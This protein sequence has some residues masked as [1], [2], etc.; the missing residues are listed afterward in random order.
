MTVQ[1]APN[2]AGSFHNVSHSGP[3]EHLQTVPLILYGPSIESNGRVGRPAGVV[4]IF[5]TM[6]RLAGVE[7]PGRAGRVL[8]EAVVDAA[9]P[10]KLILTVVWD[11]AGR[12][13]LEEWRG[14]WRTLAR[15]EREGTS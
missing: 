12:N 8:H 4:D 15:M 5:P 7:L 14:R 11:G 6:G 9:E 10:P 1:Q 3:W 13:V 2:Y